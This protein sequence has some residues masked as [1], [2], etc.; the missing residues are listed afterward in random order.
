[1]I[2]PRALAAAL[3]AALALALPGAVTAQAGT[4]RPRPAQQPARPQ[5][6]ARGAAAPVARDTAAKDAKD[7]VQWLPTDSVMEALQ[8]RPG[9]RVTRYQGDTVVFL[10]TEHLLRLGGLPSAV[11]R[12]RTILVGA[13]ITYN[14][15]TQVVAAMGDTV[16]LRDPEQSNDD[17]RASGTIK[18]S[19][20]ESRGVVT[21]LT[22]KVDNNGNTWTLF[23]HEAAVQT[24]EDSAAAALRAA[25]DSTA[26]PRRSAFYAHGGVITSC[27]ETEPHYHFSTAE[28]KVVANRVMVGRPAVLYIGEVPVAWIPFFFQDMRKGRRSGML[29]PR[30]GFSEF[31]RQGAGYRRNVENLGWY[32]SLGDYLDAQAAM[33]WRSSANT[34]LGGPGWLIGR[35]ALR[36]SWLSRFIDGSV[37]AQ[38][39][40]LSDGGGQSQ[41]SWVH[42][43]RFSQSSSLN[44]NWRYSTNTQVL[45]NT[46]LDPRVALGLIASQANYTRAIG[47]LSLQ[48]GG[49][50][51]QYPGR[52]QVDRTFPTLSLTSRPITLV[53]SVTWTPSVNMTTTTVQ[54][55][56]ATEFTW[57]YAARSDG[58][59]DSTARFQ[60][61]RNT[62]GSFN[63]PVKIYNFVWS[64]AFRFGDQLR[65]F[66][67]TLQ[68]RGLRDTSVNFSRTIA[69]YYET[70][71]DWDTGINLP[72]FSQGKWNLTPTVTLSNV[73]GGPFAIRNTRS[74]GDWI[75]QSKRLVYGLS[76][77]P[78]LFGIFPGVGPVR[79]I[80]HSLNPT[81]A[82]NYAPAADVSDEWLEALGKTRVGYLGAIQQSSITLGL[83]Q[84]VEIKLR[85]K[86]DSTG[87]EQDGEKVRLLS[88]QTSPFAYNFERYRIKR[89]SARRRGLEAPAWTTG[90]ETNRFNFTL[91]SDLLPGF[92]LGM[93][94]SL[95][96]GDVQSDTATFEPFRE[97]VRFSL[98][99]DPQNPIVRAIARTFGLGAG[100]TAGGRAAPGAPAGPQGQQ[101]S[102]MDPFR[103][104]MGPVTPAQQMLPT[105]QGWRASLTFSSQRQRPP[106]GG[107][108]LQTLNPR[109]A[110]RFLLPN[111]FQFDQCVL[112]P[113]LLAP[114]Q[115]PPT[116]GVGFTPVLAP[117]VTN[118]SWNMGFN[119]TPKWTAQWSTSY[120]FVTNQFA[121]QVVSF[122]RELHDWRATFAF[123]QAPNGAVFFNFFIAL[124]AEPNLKFN[125]DRRTQGSLGF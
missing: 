124:K 3:A 122:Q 28:L 82:F 37:A 115:P 113:A 69:R 1:V 68:Y 8:R 7:L 78:T 90:L 94:W 19:I 38:T 85:G 11:Q 89:D 92:D 36:Y 79:R 49:S 114:T 53:D 98:S 4:D 60:S 117:P 97:Q 70:T 25:G 67:Q 23:G 10:T 96:Q 54:Q 123:T 80:R 86:P 57:A 120:D 12:D 15:S 16:I 121:A 56:P 6:A 41:F 103:G 116:A 88:L 72:Q 21:N 77:A 84:N 24:F 42:S 93:D 31:I 45:R 47:P 64:N 104:T 106:R 125:Y 17:L 13:K 46:A 40:R 100:P 102:A 52:P 30:F 63:T 32:F 76:V 29:V 95:F 91:R 109:E 112:N 43:Q 87:L 119:L 107:P 75:R 26:D 101:P 118:A 5:P 50:Q 39:Q 55:A 65:D 9:Y 110:C 48:L 66:P 61:T 99:L 83:S 73:D 108:P 74:N 18:Y 58:R 59:V 22:T 111:T 62:T 81:L 33:D 35:G 71:L 51:T 20:P 44:V 105:G 27:D 2:R 14:D 34:G